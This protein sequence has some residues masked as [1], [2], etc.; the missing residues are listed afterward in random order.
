MQGSNDDVAQKC[1]QQLGMVVER[2][3]NEGGE[4]YTADDTTWKRDLQ[5]NFWRT[6]ERSGGINGGKSED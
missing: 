5:T 6:Q 4:K 1:R 2:I 3:F